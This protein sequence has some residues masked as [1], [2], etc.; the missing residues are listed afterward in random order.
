M[1]PAEIVFVEGGSSDDTFKECLRQKKANIQVLKQPGKGKFDAVRWGIRHATG[2]YIIIMDADLTVAPEDMSL[3]MEALDKNSILYGS[4]LRL[5][6]KPNSF[7]WSSLMANRFFALLASYALK[8]RITDTLCGT[9][10]GPTWSFRKMLEFPISFQD[11][12][13]DFTFLF[14]AKWLGLS[15]KEVPVQYWPRTYGKTNI[16]KWRDGFKLYNLIGAWLYVELAR[17]RIQT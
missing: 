16:V 6:P 5:T 9:K 2:D 14:G 4:R 15:L 10:A 3:F 17:A 1:F 8:Q 12:F 7:E 13:G 11:P